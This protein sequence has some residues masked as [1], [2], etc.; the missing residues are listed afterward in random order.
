MKSMKAFASVPLPGLPEADTTTPPCVSQRADTIREP[1]AV[2]TTTCV[3]GD[4]PAKPHPGAVQ[5]G[6]DGAQRPASVAATARS[7]RS[8]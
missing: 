6:L 1:S 5:A 7:S 2:L 8:K 3:L 4:Q